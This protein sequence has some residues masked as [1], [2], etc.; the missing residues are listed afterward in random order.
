VNS[1]RGAGHRLSALVAMGALCAVGSAQAAI[2]AWMPDV[3]Y[4]AGTVVSYKARITPRWSI[5]L[6][7]VPPDGIRRRPACGPPLEPRPAAVLRLHQRV[8]AVLLRRLP[9]AEGLRLHRQAVV[10]RQPGAPRR[11]T[12]AATPR[13]RTVPTTRRIGGRRVM[14]LQPTMGLSEADSPGPQPAA[15]RA[16]VLEP[17]VVV[18]PGPAVVAEP[19]LVVVVEPLRLRR[20]RSCLDRT[21]TSRSA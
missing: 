3:Y 4:T 13:A 14:I 7:T 17:A 11:S 1:K 9:V 19:G 18:E 20:D 21:R 2:S 8:G 6:I 10:A 12:P 15:A 16:A 5:K